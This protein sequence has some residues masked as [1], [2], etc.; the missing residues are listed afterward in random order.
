MGDLAE[1]RAGDH[2]DSKVDDI[3]FERKVPELFQPRDPA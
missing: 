3:S 1:G 2:A